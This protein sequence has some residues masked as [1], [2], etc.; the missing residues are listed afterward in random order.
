[1]KLSIPFVQSCYAIGIPH[2]IYSQVVKVFVV[3]TEDTKP[4]PEVK[5]CIMAVCKENISKL[6][7]VHHSE[8]FRLSLELEEPRDILFIPSLPQNVR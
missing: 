5:K 3:L 4:T 1:L 6:G 8:L 2:P 7:K